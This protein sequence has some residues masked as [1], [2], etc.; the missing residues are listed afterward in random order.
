MLNSL[1]LTERQREVVATMRMR[2]SREQALQYLRGVGFP[3]S[4]ATLGRIKSWLRKTEL[5]RLHQIAAIGFESQHLA[6]IDNC[7]HIEQLM[8]K[9]YFLEHNAHKRVL[10]LK[11]IKELQPYISTYYAATKS[12]IKPVDGIRQDTQLPT[13]NT[14]RRSET[15][16]ESWAVQG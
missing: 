3:M 16:S 11:E 5:Q 2:L 14:A 1:G 6:R 8:W 7:E 15:E 9:D 10:I 4:N 13:N 12:V